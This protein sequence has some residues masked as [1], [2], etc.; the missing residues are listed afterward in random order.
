MQCNCLTSEKLAPDNPEVSAGFD[1]L[2]EKLIQKES[3][4]NTAR[5][6][7]LSTDKIITY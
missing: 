5:E 6:R 3:A 1:A 4:E 2:L 7:E